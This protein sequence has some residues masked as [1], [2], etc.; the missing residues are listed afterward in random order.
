MKEKIEDG[1]YPSKKYEVNVPLGQLSKEFGDT[2]RS[3]FEAENKLEIVAMG[4]PDYLKGP[5]GEEMKQQGTVSN[6]RRKLE[7]MLNQYG[8]KIKFPFPPEGL[9]SGLDVGRDSVMG[10]EVV[11]IP[12]ANVGQV[13]YRYVSDFGNILEIFES[14][15]EEFIHSMDEALEKRK[16][17]LMRLEKQCDEFKQKTRDLFEHAQREAS[18]QGQEIL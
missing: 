4:R 16:S 6:F 1:S 10:K 5:T 14:S 3:Y 2:C 11:Y 12:G 8:K 18:G 7:A 9:V 17:E 15:S 13:N